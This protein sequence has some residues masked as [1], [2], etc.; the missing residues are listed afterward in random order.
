MLLFHIF[1]YICLISASYSYDIYISNIAQSNQVPN[2]SLIPFSSIY[3][4]FLSI[5]NITIYPNISISDEFHFKIV[6]SD[7]PYTLNDSEV[8][9]QV[10]NG[11]IGI[12]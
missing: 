6:P 12:S 8:A 11:F 10:F 1:L 7:I 4:A 9:N 3:S 2:A 5:Q